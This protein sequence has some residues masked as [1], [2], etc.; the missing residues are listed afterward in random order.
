MVNDDEFGEKGW[1]KM[2]SS[3]NIVESG[4]CSVKYIIIWTYFPLFS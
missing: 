1:L 2:G 4:A 3:V